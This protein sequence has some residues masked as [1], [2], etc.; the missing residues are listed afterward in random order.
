MSNLH[1]PIFVNIIG[2]TAGAIIFGIFL[3]LFLRERGGTPGS[4]LSASA[5]GLALLWNFGSLAVLLAIQNASPASSFLI[6]ATFCC[7]TLLPPVLLHLSLEGQM[8]VLTTIGYGLGLIAAG[9]HCASAFSGNESY[10][11]NAL[12]LITVGFVVLT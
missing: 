4:W 5:A 11:A 2:H 6:A 7:L 9:M 1:E 10:R 12:L 3:V 8:P